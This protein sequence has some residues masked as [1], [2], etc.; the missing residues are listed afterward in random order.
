M[1]ASGSEQHF[2]SA[3]G[4]F[5]LTRKYMR[6]LLVRMLMHRHNAALFD[7]PESKCALIAMNEFSKKA[8]KLF[9]DGEV[10]QVLHVVKIK[11]K[12]TKGTRDKEQGTGV[13]GIVIAFKT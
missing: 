6:D 5:Q 2:F 10:L 1:Y 12:K 3:N 13:T 4:H 8:R 11:R 7:I 9:A